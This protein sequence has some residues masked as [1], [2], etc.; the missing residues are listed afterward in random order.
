MK[1]YR[2]PVSLRIGITLILAFFSGVIN[3]AIV[4]PQQI[5]CGGTGG[6][7]L[8]LRHT[9]QIPVWISMLV[10]QT[11]IFFVVFKRIGKEFAFVMVGSILAFTAGQYLFEDS[12][13]YIESELL[14]VLLGAGYC[15]IA[16]GITMALGLSNGGMVAVDYMLVERYGRTPAFYDNLINCIIMLAMLPFFRIRKF[17]VS[18]IYLFFC[19]FVLDYSREVLLPIFEKQSTQ[20]RGEIVDEEV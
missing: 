10:A 12:R 11:A 19:N 15:G 18:L 16:T 4:I 14:S 7:A 20:N 2:L 1:Q 9:L 8:I 6:I 3:N 13:I 17:F 5:N